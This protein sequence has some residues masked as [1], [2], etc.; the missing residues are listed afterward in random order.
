MKRLTRFERARLIGARALQLSLGAPPLVKPKPDMSAY[1][2]AKLEFE[3]RVL[4]LSVM[5]KLPSGET[6]VVRV[7]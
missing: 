2:L 3:K 1:D 4:P 7:E 6:V 5:R